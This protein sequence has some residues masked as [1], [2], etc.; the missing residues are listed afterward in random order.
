MV[1]EPASSAASAGVGV[2]AATVV[3]LLGVEPQALIYSSLGAFIGL[4]FAPRA[5]RVH[6]ALQFVAVVLIAA[7]VGTWVATE[8]AHSGIAARTVAA[9]ATAAIFHPTFSAAVDAVPK[10]VA[11]VSARWDAKP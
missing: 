3:A 2:A 10:L 11:S 5:G 4:G 1:P 9:A 8:W 6:A 7:A